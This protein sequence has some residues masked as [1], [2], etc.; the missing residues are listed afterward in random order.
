MTDDPTPWEKSAL[1]QHLAKF[2]RT[3]SVTLPDGVEVLVIADVRYER[4]RDCPPATKSG[5][6]LLAWLKAR[7]APAYVWYQGAVYQGE[8]ADWAIEQ[9]R[10]VAGDCFRA[11]DPAHLLASA[12]ELE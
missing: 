2:A 9:A 4:A 6:S 7:G 12:P 10:Q 3:C 8:H 1:A 5:E 11:A